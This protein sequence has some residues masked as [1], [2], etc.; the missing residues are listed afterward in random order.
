MAEKKTKVA[1]WRRSAAVGRQSSGPNFLT[2]YPLRSILSHLFESAS[3]TASTTIWE[4]WSLANVWAKGTHS[5]HFLTC[6][7]FV[8]RSIFSLGVF[9]LHAVRQSNMQRGLCGDKERSLGIITQTHP[10]RCASHPVSPF[11]AELS[12]P[13]QPL[14]LMIQ[15]VEISHPLW[16]LPS[17]GFMSKINGRFFNATRYRGYTIFPWTISTWH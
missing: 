16:N 14:Q 9:I 15:W 8:M 2:F 11:T 13:V 10:H 7:L 3:M 17:Y 6:G 1:T 4:K 5:F 12:R